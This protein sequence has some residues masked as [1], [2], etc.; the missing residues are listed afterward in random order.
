[1]TILAAGGRLARRVDL[2]AFVAQKQDLD[3]GWMTLGRWLSTYPP[4]GARIEALAPQYGQGVVVRGQGP[5][6]A[7][8]ILAGCMVIP[9]LVSVLAMALWLPLFRQMMTA[10]AR[11]ASSA[12][13]AS[14]I[15]EDEEGAPA[16]I[17]AADVPAA[18][19]TA[20]A[21]LERIAGV[22][23]R[24]AAAGFP[25]NDDTTLG[26]LWAAHGEEGSMPLDPFTGR[27]YEFLAEEGNESALV[28]SAGPD[29]VIA[30]NDDLDRN[31]T[32][33]AGAERP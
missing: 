12:F 19:T 11:P 23:E 22:V 33:P 4:L 1:L 31:I 7:A 10:G 30:T 5:V 6:R 8:G 21:D 3:T 16:R 28:Y 2:N 27:A 20:R 32:L 13:A 17:P 29:A 25:I 9:S 18:Y 24:A 26:E 14:S 15:S